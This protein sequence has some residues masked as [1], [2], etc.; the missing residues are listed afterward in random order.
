MLQTAFAH[1][2]MPADAE[3]IEVCGHAAPLVVTDPV[4]EYT[5]VRERLGLYDFSMLHKYDVRGPEALAAIDAAVCRDLTRVAPGRIA[6]G[7]VVG[8]DGGMLDDSTVF[9]FGPDHVRVVGGDGVPGAVDAAVSGRD[10]TAT[11]VREA[12]AHL[13]LQGPKSREVLARIAAFDV[14]NDAFPYYTF[15][16]GVDVAGIPALVSRMGFSAELGYEIYIPRDRADDLW[17]AIQE[18][19]A[20]LDPRAIGGAAVMM[21]RIEAGM[22]MGDGLEYDATVSPWECGLGWAVNLD[23]PSF[24]GKDALARR[25]ESDTGRVV[26][27]RLSGGED[28]ATG[29][30]L[31][32]GED[33]VGHVTMSIPSPFLGFATLGLARVHRDLAAPGTRLEA[34]L[35]EGAYEAEIVSTP[36]YDPERARV[37]S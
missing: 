18:A 4:E 21:I 16:D 23:K 28:R 19:A 31:F 9:V 29:A 25:K 24:R 6:Y 20:G 3:V 12:L 34:R 15:R 8:D 5:A 26:S 17:D 35:E 36:V 32:H 10:C 13:T 14:S 37:R 11:P 2:F 27:V 1:R 7:P 30:P 33:E 22:V